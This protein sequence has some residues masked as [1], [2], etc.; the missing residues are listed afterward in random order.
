MSLFWLRERDQGVGGDK[1]GLEVGERPNSEVFFL[2]VYLLIYHK[3][4]EEAKL[5][6]LDSN[7]L[8]INAID[9]IFNEIEFSGEIE[10]VKTGVE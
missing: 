9:G 6:N 1:A 10:G 3:C 7:R 2:Q 4:D 5:G 8:D